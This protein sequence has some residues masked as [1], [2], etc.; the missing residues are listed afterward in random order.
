MNR[1]SGPCPWHGA[2]ALQAVTQA[3]EQLRARAA[4]TN[5]QA[6]GNVVAEVGVAAL[7]L[8]DVLGA[9]AEDLG[10]QLGQGDAGLDHLLAPVGQH[11]GG[12]A[13]ALGLA[14]EVG[15]LAQ[16]AHALQP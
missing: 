6:E 8:G 13:G 5:R 11:D 1:L 7:G 9:V 2:S 16:L 4:L 10:I 14:G 3:F 12:P 15:V